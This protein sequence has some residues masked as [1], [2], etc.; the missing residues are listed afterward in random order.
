MPLF[1]IEFRPFRYLL[2]VLVVS[3]LRGATH[4]DWQALVI[5]SVC[6]LLLWYQPLLDAIRAVRDGLYQAGV[7]L[8]WKWCELFG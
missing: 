4:G 8:E 5:L 3:V 7:W 1:V 2:L 6:V